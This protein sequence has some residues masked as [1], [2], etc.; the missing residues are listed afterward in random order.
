MRNRIILL[1][2]MGLV[3]G[4]LTLL[5]VG[6]LSALQPD[7]VTITHHVAQPA[8][9]TLDHSVDGARIFAGCLAFVAGVGLVIAAVIG[10]DLR[11]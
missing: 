5:A 7:I 10:T 8:Y 3:V 9:D 6:L 11:E 2:V 4:S 1:A